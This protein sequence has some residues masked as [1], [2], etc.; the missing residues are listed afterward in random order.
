[1]QLS[2]MERRDRQQLPHVNTAMLLESKFSKEE[3][4]LLTSTMHEG[5]VC[6]S[7]R[8]IPACV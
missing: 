1:M 3:V 2:H 4:G 6:T 8:L 5:Q 7:A